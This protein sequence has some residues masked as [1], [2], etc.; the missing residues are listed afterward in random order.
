MNIAEHVSSHETQAH[1]TTWYASTAVPAP[2]RPSLN[3]DV[4]VDVCVVG[5]GL[6]GLTT[7]REL[8]RRGWSVAVLEARRIAWNASGRN[9]GFVAPGFAERLP[10]IFDRVGIERAKE[11]FNLSSEGADYVARLIRESAMPGVEA[12]PGFLRVRRFE[13]AEEAAEEAALLAAEFGVEAEAWPKEQVRE[14]LRTEAYYQGVFQPHA[15]HIHPLNYALGLAAAA[16]AAGAKIFEA[17]PAVSMDPA[18]VR[19]RVDTPSGRVRAAH[20][21]LAGGPHLGAFSR[22]V[23]GTVVPVATHIGVTAPLGERL[24]DAVRLSGAV[25]DTRRVGNYFRIVG[26]DRLLWGGGLTARLAESPRLIKRLQGDLG[27]V[28][29]Q[30]ADVPM[31]WAWSGHM[32]YAVHKMPQIGEIAPGIWLAGAFGGHGINTTA[33]AGGLIASAI[34]EGDDRWRLFSDYELVWAGGLLGRGATQLLSWSLRMRDKAVEWQAR[35]NG[36]KAAHRFP[37]RR[38]T[39]TDRGPVSGPR[40]A[41]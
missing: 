38:R 6:A 8:A 34:V 12:V 2:E 19:K 13:A 11:L 7:A 30:L 37:L 25:A 32:A 27:Q 24:L 23:S 3:H 21:V 33:M 17:T 10:R 36:G 40:G 35:R 29:P 18:G 20:V 1:A 31:E 15:F 41:P 4:D 28:F 16:E 9:G 22:Y 26:K 14:S 5:A 39:P